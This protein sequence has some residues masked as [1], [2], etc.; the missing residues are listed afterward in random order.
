MLPVMKLVICK[1]HYKGT[2]GQFS[3][4]PRERSS[5]EEEAYA[6]EAVNDRNALTRTSVVVRVE[7]TESELS[8]GTNSAAE[9]D[10]KLGA[11]NLARSNE[12]V[13]EGRAGDL[14]SVRR[15][16]EGQRCNSR[17]KNT[18]TGRS[19]PSAWKDFPKD[20]DP[21]CHPAH[22]R[23]QAQYRWSA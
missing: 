7:A 19:A 17:K 18:R 20:Q 12:V 11:R 21:G 13:E 10:A 14:W 4:R 23:S 16:R 9:E 2:Q 5:K 22:H 6:T 15:W 1:T 3:S 8:N